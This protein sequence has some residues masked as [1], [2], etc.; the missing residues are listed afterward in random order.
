M[1]YCTNGGCLTQAARMMAIEKARANPAKK[2]FLMSF[3]I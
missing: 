2:L 3:F 1:E